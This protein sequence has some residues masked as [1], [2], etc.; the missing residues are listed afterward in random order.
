MTT[1]HHPLGLDRFRNA[2]P[3]APLM[4][5]SALAVVFSAVSLYILGQD[6]GAVSPPPAQ[7][8]VD[9]PEAVEPPD[10]PGLDSEGAT[11]VCGDWERE[12]ERVRRSG[13]I[14]LKA[15]RAR[16]EKAM[17]LGRAADAAEIPDRW[18][19]PGFDGTETEGPR[20]PDMPVGVAP[21][22]TP[23]KL[24]VSI[25]PPPIEDAVIRAV[26]TENR[27]EI[28]R[29]YETRGGGP[30]KLEIALAVE[31]NGEISEAEIVGV[32]P[33]ARAVADCI[34]TKARSWRF[35]PSQGPA[36]REVII[37][38]FVVRGNG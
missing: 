16:D 10:L 36:R 20:V 26:A 14:P 11:L 33:V 5:L 37:P 25:V 15:A 12:A 34:V 32:A 28:E 29:C 21:R 17:T 23:P 27:R 6:R 2:L 9:R 4:V 3:P 1:H 8:L 31:P 22:W 18:S 30:D 35:P 13:R 19:H 38:F 24:E 7:D